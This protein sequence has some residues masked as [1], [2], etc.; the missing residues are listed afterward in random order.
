MAKELK[1]ANTEFELTE[2]FWKQYKPDSVKET[3]LSGALRDYEK[4]LKE[5]EK[6]DNSNASPVAK[7]NKWGEVRAALHDLTDAMPTAINALGKDKDSHKNLK[8]SLERAHKALKGK[9]H[10]AYKT[11]EDKAVLPTEDEDVGGE[12]WNKWIAKIPKQDI[13][14]WTTV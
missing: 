2:A 6:L 14:N 9:T 11:A 4:K 10:A 1:N 12:A 8:A 5:A 7:A 3:G 13:R